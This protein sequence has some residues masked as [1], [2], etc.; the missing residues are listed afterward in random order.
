[1]A[2]SAQIIQSMM[3]LMLR[4][5]YVPKDFVSQVNAIEDM[6]DDDVTGLVDSLTDFAMESATT[7]ISIEC[8][9]DNLERNLNKWLNEDLNKSYLGMIPTGIKAL[10]EQYYREIWKGSTFPVLKIGGWRKIGTLK[11]PTKMY[12]LEG[13]SVKAQEKNTKSNLKTVLPYK[14]MVGNTELNSNV[15]ISKPYN[16][17]YDKYPTPFLIK[18]GVYHNYEIIR[19]LKKHQ[20]KLLEQIIP[21]ILLITKGSERA[22]VDKDLSYDDGQLNKLIEQMQTL[23]N[24]QNDTSETDPQTAVRAREWDEKIK[25]LIPDISTIF[26]P[27]LFAVAEKQ[28]LSGLGFID[29]AEG[30]TNNRRESILNP[31]V[32]IKD[33]KT[34]NSHFNAMLNEV[35]KMIKLKNSDNYKYMNKKIHIVSA[36]IDD[37]I[38]DKFRNQVRQMYDRGRISSRTA[39]EVVAEKDFEIEVLRRE[40][41]K[42]NNIETKMYPVITRNQEKHSDIPSQPKEIKT[43][44]DTDEESIPNDKKDETEKQE[45]DYGALVTA[46]YNKVSELPDKVKNNMS[47]S[48]QKVFMKTVNKALKT[49]DG[50]DKVAFKVAWKTIKEIGEKNKEGKWVRA[51]VDGKAKYLTKKVLAR[52][53]EEAEQDIIE[54]SFKEES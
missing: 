28:I 47:K 19:Q 35:I 27:E 42:K 22:Y 9:N 33:V 36:P 13:K 52:I 53:L 8:S 38:T 24:K 2:D 51:K 25:H 41:E 18:R 26:K 45:Y 30:I 5:V 14:Y 12:F 29:I 43:K 1:M 31:K 15:V 49:Y 17:W 48:L 11:L 50:N 39:V 46:P 16:K 10:S 21:Y 54:E 4:K 23:I 40:K 37:F 3:S 6:L 32:F 7:D 20:S 34:A 44:Q